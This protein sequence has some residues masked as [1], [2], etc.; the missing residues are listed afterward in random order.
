MKKYTHEQ[1]FL[2]P[3]HYIFNV[4]IILYIER[5]Q[6][7]AIIIIDNVCQSELRGRR[8]KQQLRE[9]KACLPTID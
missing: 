7:D 8:E 3:K 9:I 2:L 6:N 5:P 1:Y 4:I